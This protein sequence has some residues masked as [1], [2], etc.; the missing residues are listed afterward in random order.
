M[1]L[2]TLVERV[3]WKR[4]PWSGTSSSPMCSKAAYTAYRHR[5]GY[6]SKQI[7]TCQIFNRVGATGTWKCTKPIEIWTISPLPASGG[8]RVFAEKLI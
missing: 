6:P 2:S 4:F 8:N 5:S 1:T 7:E 3:S